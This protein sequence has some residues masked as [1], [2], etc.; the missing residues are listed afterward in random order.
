MRLLS[1][2]SKFSLDCRYSAIMNVF[3]VQIHTYIQTLLVL[4]RA[5]SGSPQLLHGLVPQLKAG[6]KPEI[7]HW[8]MQQLDTILWTCLLQYFKI[9][10]I[11]STNNSFVTV[12]SFAEVETW[13]V[14]AI[15]Q[16]SKWEEHEVRRQVGKVI[17]LVALVPHDQSLL[18]T[19]DN[20]ALPLEVRVA[21]PSLLVVVVVQGKQ[22]AQWF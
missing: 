4:C 2:F 14:A 12:K 21:L 1:A 3:T 6:S 11:R 7:C 22:E 17:S 18:P 9:F 5:R 15:K 16:F 8:N 20:S 19:G 13:R 10:C